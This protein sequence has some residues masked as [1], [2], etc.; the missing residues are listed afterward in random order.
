MAGDFTQ[1]QSLTRH[2]HEACHLRQTL[3][4]TR[5]QLGIE[6]DQF[7]EC[8][9]DMALIV[10]FCEVK[11]TKKKKTSTV[12][13]DLFRYI[14]NFVFAAQ[15]CSIPGHRSEQ[16]CAADFKL[17][18]SAAAFKTFAAAKF[19]VRRSCCTCVGQ[20]GLIHLL[21]GISG[22]HFDCEIG[23][24]K[25]SAPQS[26]FLLCFV[27]TTVSISHIQSLIWVSALRSCLYIPL[28]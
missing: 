3:R 27:T 4:L 28:L 26:S 2:C 24:S 6:A 11:K 12:G 22:H 17:W 25:P 8:Q 21:L 23:H 15:A 16:K 20:R 13:L 7:P 9:R 1:E 14:V 19:L 18:R 5:M 10:A